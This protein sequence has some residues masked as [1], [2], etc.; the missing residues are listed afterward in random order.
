[1]ATPL[2]PLPQSVASVIDDAP[3]LTTLLRQR[4]E[5]MGLWHRAQTLLPPALAQGVAIGR[6]DHE[7]WTL[8]APDAA[9]AAKLRQWAPNLAQHLRHAQGGTP[10]LGAR[11]IVIKVQ[12]P[13]Q[14]NLP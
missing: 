12:P 3:L 13:T 11:R 1:M 5:A 10:A 7:Q 6:L 4:R 9:C 14:A 8:L 2:V